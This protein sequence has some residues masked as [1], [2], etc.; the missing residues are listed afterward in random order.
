METGAQTN[1]EIKSQIDVVLKSLTDAWNNHDM[2][3]YAAQFADDADFVN[4]FGM[5]WHGRD[6]IEAQHVAIHRSIFRNSSVRVEQSSIR[7]LAPGVMLAHLNWE[8]RGHEIPPGAPFSEIRHGLMTAVFV[9]QQGQW[10]IAALH[11]SDVV[12]VPPLH[13]AS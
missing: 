5:H 6:A 1:A 10:L 3:R 12:E 13:R 4:V 9:E 11:N 8:M 2:T 7:P